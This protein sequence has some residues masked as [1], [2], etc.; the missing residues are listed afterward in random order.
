MAHPGTESQSFHDLP[1]AV[2]VERT[3]HFLKGV[4]QRLDGLMVIV[5]ACPECC[6]PQSW[7]ICGRRE[8]SAR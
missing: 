3:F 1:P 5:L 2:A 4:L 8:R 6:L 7:C